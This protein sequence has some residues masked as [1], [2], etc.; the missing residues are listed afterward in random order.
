MADSPRAA[1]ERAFK[2]VGGP[3]ALARLLNVS[4][5]AIVQW[6]QVPV[7]RVLDVEKFTSEPRW[8]LRPDIYPP[9][10]EPAS[11]GEEPPKVPPSTPAEEPK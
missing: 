1:M 10:L 6:D 4:V 2:R 7:V 5:Q 11:A 8:K 3:A 9:P